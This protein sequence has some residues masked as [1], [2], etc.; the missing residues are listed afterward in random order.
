MVEVIRHGVILQASHHS[1]ENQAVLNPTCV[2]IG[3]TVHMFYR[4]VH[5]GN[6]S[7][8]GYCRLKGP[9]EVVY[10]SKKPVLVASA[11]HEKHGIEDP[12]V[13]FV[14]GTYYM[15]YSA[16]DGLSCVVSYATSKDLKNWTKQ[17]IISPTFTYDELGNIFR[18]RT[19]K[20]K[21]RYLFF[22]E[23]FEATV[24]KKVLVWEK[25]SFIFP[26]KFKGK[27]ALIHRILPDIQIAYFKNF[28]ELNKEYWRK[29]A[30]NLKKYIV[31]EPQHGFESRNIGGGVPPIETEKGWLMIY[32][33]VEDSNQ[34]KIYHAAAALLDKNDPTKVIGRLEK[35]LFSP[36]E[37]YEKQGDV[38]NV[39]FPTGTALFGDR[40][41]IYYGAADKRIAAVSVSLTELLAELDHATNPK[42]LSEII[43]KKIPTHF[44]DSSKIYSCDKCNLKP[45]YLA[46]GWLLRDGK[47]SV[48]QRQD[49]LFVKLKK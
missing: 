4:A 17:K 30:H 25:D 26:K 45:Y 49:K 21:E 28:K 24:G 15:F 42:Y 13:V 7:S 44:V 18:E 19:F 20:L 6:H 34:G 43:L 40:L 23:Y 36:T 14:D 2:Q 31:L 16:Y 3:K 1:F 46:L 22:D 11:P 37:L 39:V 8:V 38:N 9:T 27:F 5:S 35:P 10:R 48:H 29:Y 47:I 41:Y 33:A 32:H 12:R